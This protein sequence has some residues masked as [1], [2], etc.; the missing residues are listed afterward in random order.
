[1]MRGCQLRAFYLGASPIKSTYF[2]TSVL[3]RRQG[4]ALPTK[5]PAIWK[6]RAASENLGFVRLNRHR[7]RGS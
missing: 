7:V 6:K 5:W 3:I 1:M 4:D 2:G